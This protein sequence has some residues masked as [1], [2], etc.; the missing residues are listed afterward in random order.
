M[1]NG[2]FCLHAILRGH[3]QRRN[4]IKVVTFVLEKHGATNSDHLC[5]SL[6]RTPLCFFY[7]LFPQ[8][9][10]HPLFICT[11]LPLFPHFSPVSL[12]V[13]PNPSLSGRPLW[14]KVVHF[15]NCCFFE[16]RPS[17]LLSSPVQSTFRLFY[18][19]SHLLT[20]SLVFLSIFIPLPSFFSLPCSTSYHS[21]LWVLIF[22]NFL[23]FSAIF[24]VVSFSSLIQWVSN[25]LPLARRHF[26][27]A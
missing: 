19:P 12:T 18:F 27:L 24:S 25:I 5:Y 9:N 17:P 21:R 6:D 26:S 20:S 10:F 13:S 8:R 3:H 22:W 23:L 2:V 4:W 11:H 14:K 7:L 1:G 15:W 16:V